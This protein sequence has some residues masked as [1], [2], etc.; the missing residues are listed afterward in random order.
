MHSCIDGFGVVACALGSV[1]CDRI[2]C[3]GAV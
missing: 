1:P 3:G 2:S